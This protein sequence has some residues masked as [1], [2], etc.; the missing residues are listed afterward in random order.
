MKYY[1]IINP[2]SRSG[3][4][5][6]LVPAIFNQ[7][8]RAGASYESI[9]IKNIDDVNASAKQALESDYDAI[10]AVG[11]DGTINAVINAFFDDKGKLRAK[12]PLGIIY[13]GTSP[14]F[15]KSYNIPLKTTPAVE[16]LLKNQVEEIR[17]G[18][19]TCRKDLSAIDNSN[20][21]DTLPK[22]VY[23]ACCANIGLGASVARLAN[24]NRKYLGDF[25]GTFVA[26]IISIVRFHSCRFSVSFDGRETTISKL[27]NLSVGKTPFIASGIR[28]P[29]ALTF[30]TEAFYY[31]VARSF[32]ILN[33][34]LV[35][36]QIYRGKIKENSTC[37]YY[38]H[39]NHIEIKANGFAAEIE[40]DGDPVGY[41]PC[42]IRTV[43][44]KIR[45]IVKK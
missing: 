29:S 3:K 42:S 37:L 43:N 16:T 11:G 44:D 1:L 17:V 18:E 9:I 33:L 4:S 36:Y 14:D 39:A 8:N 27:Y 22:T 45:V 12:T 38:G 26:L 19:I 6:K 13:T 24:K 31:L 28:V 40:A 25:L 7:L 32:S 15:C 2:G 35:L 5:Q 41:L 30:Q 10:V 23:F 34:P 20:Q 21:S